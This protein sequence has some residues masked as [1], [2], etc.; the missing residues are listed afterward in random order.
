M[1]KAVIGVFRQEA[2]AKEAINDL[3]SQEFGDREISL[4]AKDKR[5]EAGDRGGTKAEWSRLP[6]G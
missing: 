6:A 1:S 2:R 4:I 3:K 5:D